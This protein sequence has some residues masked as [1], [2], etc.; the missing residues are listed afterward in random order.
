MSIRPEYFPGDDGLRF[1]ADSLT[2]AP[3]AYPRPH[4][5]AAASGP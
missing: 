2:A 1:L 3:I 5:L 4:R